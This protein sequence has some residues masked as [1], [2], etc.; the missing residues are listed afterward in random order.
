M[1]RPSYLVAISSSSQLYSGTGR[2]LFDWLALAAKYFDCSLIIDTFNLDS[3]HIAAKECAAIDVR[4]FTSRSNP[5]PGLIDSGMMDLPSHLRNHQ[6]D[7]VECISWANGAT[8]LAAL[9][10]CSELTKIVFTP[11]S[12]P[13]W[14]IPD[15]DRHFLVEPA[16]RRMLEGSDLIFV[17]SPAEAELPAFDGVLRG[18]I[19]Y[20]PLGVDASVF[21]PSE[22]TSID[23]CS[24]LTVSDFRERRKRFDALASSFFKAHQQDDQLKLHLVGRGAAEAILGVQCLE[25]CKVYAHPRLS[26]DELV[27]IYQRSGAF[28]LMSDYEAFGLPIAEALLCGCPV[29]LNDIPVVRSLF[30][31]LPGVFLAD[32]R[33]PEAV[34][35][36]LFRALAFGT[37][38]DNRAITAQQAKLRFS[39]TATQ[40]IKL[41]SIFQLLSKDAPPKR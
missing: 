39:L 15:P 5:L 20:A 4:L 35:E 12:Q 41:S 24:V 19:V 34:A 29:V 40:D 27:A 10:A 16:F 13:L 37:S 7:V 28:A 26:R 21:S 1:N 25:G 3:V 14:T 38:P 32:N 31:D 23:N 36:R 9:E 22:K 8:N 30:S 11:H 17:D 33:E 2:A 6:Y 18:K